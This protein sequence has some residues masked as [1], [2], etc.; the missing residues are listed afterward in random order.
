MVVSSVYVCQLLSLKGIVRRLGI[1]KAIQVLL[2]TLHHFYVS[3][4]HMQFSFHNKMASWEVC[5]RGPACEDSN[6]DR[7][8]DTEEVINILIE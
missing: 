7:S 5:E 6:M 4:Y 1:A 8:Q 2:F 3:T